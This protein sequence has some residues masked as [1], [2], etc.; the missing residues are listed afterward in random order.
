MLSIVRGHNSEMRQVL[1]ITEQ[2]QLRVWAITQVQ[3][4]DAPNQTKTTQF[5]F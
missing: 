1:F 5:T 3:V 2:I 4:E